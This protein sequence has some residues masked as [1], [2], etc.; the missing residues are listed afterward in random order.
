MDSNIS[1][2]ENSV[3][4]NQMVSEEAIR[5]GLTLLSMQPMIPLKFIEVR[6]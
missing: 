3:Y 6:P 1:S 5:A 4:P 2:I